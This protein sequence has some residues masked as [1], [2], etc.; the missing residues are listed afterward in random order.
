[1][2][3]RDAVK[4][5]PYPYRDNSLNLFRLILAGLVLVA[6]S[7]H[8]AGEGDGPSIQGENLGGW[9]VAGFFAISGFLI[10]GSR[11]KHTAGNYIVHRVARIF[12][13]FI[14][15]LIVTAFVFAPIVALV[16]R[17]TL[18]G[19]LSTPTTPLQYV[20]GNAGL[21]IFHYDISGTLATVP[22]PSAWNGSL[23]TLYYEFLCYITVWI[24]GAFFL[25]RRFPL[26]V[27]S[28]LFA[29][30]VA[31]YANI[32]LVRR[33]GLDFDFE[34]FM[35]LLPF[36][37]GGALVHFVVARHG[38][39]PVVAAGALVLTVALIA[40]I[41]RWGGQLSSP[42]LAYT[43]LYLATVIPQPAFIARND[44]SYGFY[45]YAWPI[46]QLLVLA[47]VAALGM[48]V[49]IILAAIVTAGLAYLSWIA[50]ERPALA[51]VRP[52]RTPTP[53]AIDESA[54]PAA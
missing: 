37:L 1:V 21:H 23:W 8:I 32:D 29:A 2:T 5:Q 51:V 19:F 6:H 52:R 28:V 12:P 4:G 45:I 20:W 30:S 38:I 53:T 7:F 50:V 24:L 33:L 42:F 15:C 14:V 17:G 44:I 13:A 49:Y 11:L 41:P 9:A 18:A 26:T 36:F 43:L 31:A 48:P 10:T 35:R 46:Q 34:L 40:L 16:E 54:R 27:L 22:Y 25:F 39:S 47:G 3:I